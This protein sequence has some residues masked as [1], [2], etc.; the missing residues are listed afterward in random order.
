VPVE[1]ARADARLARDLVERC[2]DAFG[3]EARI[4]HFKDALVIAQ[5][6]RTQRARWRNR[7]IGHDGFLL[8]RA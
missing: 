7:G 8:H 5:G 2:A 4:R 3:K 6:V 1:R